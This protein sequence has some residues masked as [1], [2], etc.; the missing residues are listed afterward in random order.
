MYRRD[1]IQNPK[2]INFRSVSGFTLVELLVVIA[3]I[4]ILVAM[5]LPAVQAAREA[6]RR[7]QCGNN[8]KQIGVAFHNYHDAH[9]QFPPGASQLQAATGG[10]SDEGGGLH[11]GA[12]HSWHV[13]ILPFLEEAAIYDRLDFASPPVGPNGPHIRETLINGV[14][15]A[16][17][18]VPYAKCPSDASPA[19]AQSPDGPVAWTNYAGNRGTMKADLHGTCLQYNVPGQ[20]RPLINTESVAGNMMANLWGDCIGAASCSGIMGN[21]GYGA[22][23]AEIRDGTS[24]VICAGEI[25][26]LCRGDAIDPQNGTPVYGGDMWS[27]NRISN[28][29]FTN[30]PINTDTCQIGGPVGSCTR[31]DAFQMSRGFKSSH[32]GGGQFVFC[33]GS[34]RFLVET[35]DLLTYQRLGDRADGAVTDQDY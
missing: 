8:I 34:V 15:L 9:K 3:I 14:K 5:L 7:M 29:T 11:R 24:K 18:T 19:V 20:L 31:P 13:C 16:G 28:N 22:Q 10:L 4:G 23:I 17:T 32:S 26:P 12:K 1:E 25:L 27:F 6:G 35:M 2:S 33:D 21:A 30:A